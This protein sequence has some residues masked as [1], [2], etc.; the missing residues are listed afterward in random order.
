[1]GGLYLVCTTEEQIE[2]RWMHWESLEFDAR[3]KIRGYVFCS[4]REPIM[5][6]QNII[7]EV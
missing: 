6:R 2:F 5:H 7:L 3:L 4:L 1:M